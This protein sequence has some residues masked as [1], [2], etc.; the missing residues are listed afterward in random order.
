MLYSGMYLAHYAPLDPQQPNWLWGV[1]VD[2]AGRQRGQL[3]HDGT[4][5]NKVAGVENV[6]Q[7]GLE[8]RPLRLK[9]AGV[10]THHIFYTCNSLVLDGLH[11]CGVG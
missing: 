9:A 7:L 4:R 8:T 2:G 10:G 1:C 5:G 11:H 6:G 3:H